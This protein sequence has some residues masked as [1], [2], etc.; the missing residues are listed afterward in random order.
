MSTQV[1]DQSGIANLVDAHFGANAA[2]IR[3][4]D[5]AGVT[6]QIFDAFVASAEPDGETW[7]CGIFLDDERAESRLLGRRLTNMSTAAEVSSALAHIETYARLRLSSEYL[8]A[9]SENRTPQKLR[10]PALE[11]T[12]LPQRAIRQLVEAHFGQDLTRLWFS[13]E[14]G[15]TFELFD[16]LTF[17]ARAPR[18]ESGWTFEAT[19]PGGYVESNLLGQDL[20][21]LSTAEEIRTALSAVERYARLRLNPEYLA[22]FAAAALRMAKRK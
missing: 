20:I 13:L 2:G 18:T 5:T 17:E 19:L 15:V 10:M 4:R 6:F 22:T 9:F 3:F 11:P 12:A 16:A 21:N 14:D 1:L 7:T 8:A